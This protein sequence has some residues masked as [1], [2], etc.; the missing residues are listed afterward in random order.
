MEDLRCVRFCRELD[1]G[2]S[3]CEIRHCCV[4]NG[5]FAGYECD[6]YNDCEKLKRILGEL[7]YESCI[8]NHREI[9]RLGLENWLTYGKKHHY[10]DT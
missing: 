4:D 9:N 3:K 8:K 6:H 2:E 10:W 5:F 7:H 1:G